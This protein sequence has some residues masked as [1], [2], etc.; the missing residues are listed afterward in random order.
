MTVF[1]IITLNL[2]LYVTLRVHLVHK[3]RTSYRIF[4]QDA[5]GNKQTLE[6]TIQYLLEQTDVQNKKIAYLCEEMEKQWLSIEQIKIVTGADK[7]CTT[8][9][10]QDC[11]SYE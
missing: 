4:L 7:F 1:W 9:P 6:H 10:S 2:I 8:R 11:N 5:D 3:F